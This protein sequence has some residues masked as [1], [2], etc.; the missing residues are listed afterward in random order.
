MEIVSRVLSSIKKLTKTPS[1]NLLL[2]FLH[3]VIL[4]MLLLSPAILLLAT[5]CGP[6]LALPILN[7]FFSKYEDMAPY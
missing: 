5:I 3:I 2:Q 4:T 7:M 1:S 6:M